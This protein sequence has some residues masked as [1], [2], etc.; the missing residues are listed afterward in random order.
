MLQHNLYPPYSI[1]YFPKG[2][3]GTALLFNK[4]V[5]RLCH[6]YFPDPSPTHRTYFVLGTLSVITYTKSE[7]HG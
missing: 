7:Y 3:F 5:S 1:P 2:C 4:E 6:R